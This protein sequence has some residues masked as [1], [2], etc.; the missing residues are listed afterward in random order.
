M[1]L[2]INGMIVMPLLEKK[3]LTWLM[4]CPQAESAPGIRRCLRVAF[5]GQQVALKP[6]TEG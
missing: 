5:I 2:R 6:R 1:F 4:C 3:C